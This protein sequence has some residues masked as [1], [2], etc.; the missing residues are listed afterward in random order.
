[1][2]DLR[3]KPTFDLRACLLL[4]H[5]VQSLSQRRLSRARKDVSCRKDGFKK[6]LSLSGRNIGSVCGGWILCKLT[7]P[8]NG[9]SAARRSLDCLNERPALP[10]SLFLMS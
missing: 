8:L 10:F 4:G 9:N 2:E 1:M 5:K 6:V 7:A 3:P